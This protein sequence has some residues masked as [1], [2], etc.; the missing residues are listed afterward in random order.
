MESLGHMGPRMDHWQ[1]PSRN[2]IENILRCAINQMKAGGKVVCAW[3][4]VVERNCVDWYAMTDLWVFI[5]DTLKKCAGIGQVFTTKKNH[6][7]Q[8][9]VF[10]ESGAPEGVH[11]TTIPTKE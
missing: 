11:S 1:T 5:D 4:P 3:T 7:K 2:T 9:R 6:V 10:L 8:G